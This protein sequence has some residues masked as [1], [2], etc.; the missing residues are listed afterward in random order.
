MANAHRRRRKREDAIVRVDLNGAM[1]HAIGAES[2]L[3][4]RELATLKPRLVAAIE[5]LQEERAR[6]LRPFL[7]LP[8][9]RSALDETLVLAEE[10]RHDLEWFVMLGIGGSALGARAIGTALA[11]G[12]GHGGGGR[13]GLVVADNID[14]RSL[15]ALLDNLD[16][17]RTVFNVVSKSGETAETV[18]Q[19]L[20]VRERL[21]RELGAVD[22][23]RHLL[24]TT[25]ADGGSLRQIVNDEG[26]T[27]TSFPAGV[28]GRY[29]VLS[30]VHLLP[31][32]LLDV[33]VAALL[34]GAAA[35]DE[36]VKTTTIEEN[37]AAMLAAVRYL[38][39]TLHGASI[40]VL[41]PYT[42]CLS[43]FASWWCELWAESLGKRLERD[44]TVLAIGQT[45]VRALGATDQH[46]QVQLYADGPA[47][48]V[49]TFVRV[50]EH[51]TRVE[52]PRSYPDIEDVAYLGG[53]TLG[54]LLNMEQRATELA[55]QKRGRPTLTI[56]MPAL[57]AFTLGQLFYLMEVETALA[58]ALYGVDPY[59][60]PGIEEGKRLTFGL[61]GKPGFEAEQREVEA[62]CSQ[63]KPD[64]V[65]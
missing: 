40:A 57:T 31:A 46:S 14:P 55:L 5:Q 56:E 61:A 43:A 47:D 64:L 8:Y 42:D 35:M 22:Y 65:V 23:A 48:K 19:F 4:Q 18:A 3:S 52:I 59:N 11:P 45:P 53:H 33:D 7:D 62:W 21:L 26:F 24:I 36:R 41:M 10:L 49:V 20:V 44:G 34:D 39:D 9:Q 28:G 38:L 50:E 63:K 16:L 17:R 32:A 51:G 13:I 25:D 37:P 29:S 12:G 27:A 15:A 60:Q 58:C 1:E 6:G 2:G 54:D 30:S